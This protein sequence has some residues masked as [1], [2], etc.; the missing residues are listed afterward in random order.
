MEERKEEFG[1]KLGRLGLMKEKGWNPIAILRSQP[2]D[3]RCIIP[4]SQLYRLLKLLKEVE[5]DQKFQYI[6]DVQVSLG[7]LLFCFS[8][9]HVL[10][11]QASYLPKLVCEALEICLGSVPCGLGLFW[12]GLVRSKPADL[13]SNFEDCWVLLS[14]NGFHYMIQMDRLMI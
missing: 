1:C 7:D 3:P 6:L 4:I 8:V 5:K 10:A 2:L 9:P 14:L 11:G 12:A 13:H